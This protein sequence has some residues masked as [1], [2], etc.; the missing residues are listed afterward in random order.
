MAFEGTDIDAMFKEAAGA[1][2]ETGEGNVGGKS[3]IEPTKPEPRLDPKPQP[4][5]Q[6]KPEESKPEPAKKT[7]PVAKVDTVKEKAP[8]NIPV[9]TEKP[10]GGILNTQKGVTEDSIGRILDMNET[11]AK[12][13]ETQKDFVSG[14][15]QLEEGEKDISKVIYRALIASQRDLDAL[16]KI[17]KAKGYAAAERAFYLMGLEN[18]IIEDIYEQVEILTGEL[19]AKGN[20]TDSNK[21]NVCRKIE[22]VIAEMPKDVFTYIEKLQIFTNK[23]VQ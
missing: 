14:Y 23:A 12:F 17:V 1:A 3:T 4:Q 8:E 20:V 19:G 13:D 15:F 22:G 11:F 10:T 6:P 9:L 18:S 7:E 5:A 21:L 16:K 2:E